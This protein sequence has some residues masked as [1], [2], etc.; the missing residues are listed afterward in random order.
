MAATNTRPGGASL[1]QADYAPAVFIVNKKVVPSNNIVIGSDPAQIRF[2]YQQL[3]ILEEDVQ[4]VDRVT[5][6]MLLGK[7]GQLFRVFAAHRIDLS[8]EMRNKTG[9]WSAEPIVK[10]SAAINCIVKLA[11][12]LLPQPE[13]K[14]NRDLLNRIGDELTRK[15]VEDVRALIWRAV[16]LL[17]FPPEPFKHWQDPWE[18]SKAWLDGTMD[19]NKRLNALYKRLVGYSIY[20]TKGEDAVKKLGFKPHH[21]Q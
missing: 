4:Q 21:L 2:L 17:E 6:D 11:T 14:L 10:G 1:V 15:P 12:T 19:P 18:V 7:E 13:K 9:F 16:W 3:D 20:I 5:D 8:P